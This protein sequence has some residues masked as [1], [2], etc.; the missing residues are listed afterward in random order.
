MNNYSDTRG[1]GKSDFLSVSRLTKESFDALLALARDMRSKDMFHD[2]LR[3]KNIAL[4]FEKPSL[5]TRV[6]FEVA[7]R[8]LGG[9][10]VL[11]DSTEA[12]LGE[13]ES[14]PDLARNLSL[15]VD[16][17]VARVFSHR[18]LEE[19]ALF[20]SVP[21]VNALSDYEHPCQAVA[22]VLTLADI[23]PNFTHKQLVY[24]GDWNNVSRSLFH[25][26]RLAGLGFRAVCPEPYGPGEDQQVEWSTDTA[27][28]EGADAIYTDVWASMGQEHELPERL[29]IFKPYQV[30]EKLLLKTGKRT[31]FMH[32]LP[33]HRGQEVVDLVI[34]SEDSLVFR[35][36]A[37]RLP[38]EKAI[39]FSL[40]ENSYEAS[41]E[42]RAGLFRRI[43]HDHH[44]V[45]Q[46][47]LWV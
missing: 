31:L 41:E 33:A 7:T 15:W 12:R 2:A 38:V 45:A 11:L 35:Q 28:V 18:A 25:A 9:W 26:C 39:L 13:R 29:E 22:D 8:Q 3:G 34:E 42:G 32:C 30:N 4:I 44:P 1:T 16:G 36:A 14:V 23:W 21:V 17:I 19:L 5:R 10:P 27:A 46:R 20:A 40:L 37:N 47:K 6:T 43:G 24:I